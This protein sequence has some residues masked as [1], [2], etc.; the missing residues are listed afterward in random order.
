[1]SV[2]RALA[3]A[4]FTSDDPTD[5][6]QREAW[7]LRYVSLMVDE[8][9]TDGVAA[10]DGLARAAAAVVAPGSPPMVLIARGRLADGR[11]A[12][13]HL[14]A[15]LGEGAM[16]LWL[17]THASA[18]CGDD[19]RGHRREGDWLLVIVPPG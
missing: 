17:G 14:A 16:A 12:Y 3:Q 10:A 6:L 13:A 4:A 2:G 8:R 18:G 9:A 19:T 1:M 5:A 7:A 15:Q 11:A